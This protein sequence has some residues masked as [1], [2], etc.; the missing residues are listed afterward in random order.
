MRHSQRRGADDSLHGERAQAAETAEA[1]A[2]AVPVVENEYFT[3]SRAG[4][5]TPLAKQGTA[6]RRE[7][8]AGEVFKGG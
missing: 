6:A 8:L 5:R 1:I 4:V 3:K 7:W 2:N